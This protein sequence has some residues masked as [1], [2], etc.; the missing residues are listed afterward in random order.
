MVTN[1]FTGIGYIPTNTQLRGVDV[2]INGDGHYAEIDVYG[3]SQRM[4]W[5][6]SIFP[7]RGLS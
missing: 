3:P 5:M 7:V 4:V 1:L 6:V 2:T